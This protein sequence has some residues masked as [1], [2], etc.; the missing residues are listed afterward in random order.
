MPAFTALAYTRKFKFRPCC[1]RLSYCALLPTIRGFHDSVGYSRLFDGKTAIDTPLSKNL[2]WAV[3][4]PKKIYI[5]LEF[6]EI[7]PLR[8]FKNG[9]VE[10]I[11][12]PTTSSEEELCALEEH[13]EKIMNSAYRVPQPD[14]SFI[15]NQHILNLSNPTVPTVLHGECVAVGMVEEAELT[16]HLEIPDHVAVPRITKCI[17][18]YGLPV[19]LEDPI[20]TNLVNGRQYPVEQILFFVS[21]DKNND[22]PSKKV[23]LLSAVGSTYEQQASVFSNEK[24]LDVFQGGNWI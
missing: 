1:L 18:A 20:I 15:N 2:I 11:K 17:A 22:G 12:V 16:C 13:T 8:E 9:M 21:L 7:L 24:I 6:L 10:V 19:S 5:D 3:G 23:V 14:L 4:Q